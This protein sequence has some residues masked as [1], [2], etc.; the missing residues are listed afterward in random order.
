MNYKGTEGQLQ[1]PELL[2][3]TQVVKLHALELQEKI[4]LKEVLLIHLCNCTT[5]SIHHVEFLN[6]TD[7]CNNSYLAMFTT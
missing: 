1:N 5:Q 6:I 4:Q 7:V 3:D 2:L